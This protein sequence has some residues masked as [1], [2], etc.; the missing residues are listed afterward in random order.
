MKSRKR[1]SFQ[2]CFVMK[3][4]VHWVKV[5]LVSPVFGTIVCLLTERKCLPRC[6]RAKNAGLLQT[7]FYVSMTIVTSLRRSLLASEVC[8]AQAVSVDTNKVSLSAILTSVHS[9]L[10]TVSVSDRGRSI[11][12]V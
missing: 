11:L 10:K 3:A 1:P 8:L 5:I 7:I 2:L 12:M 6:A 9:R 4:I